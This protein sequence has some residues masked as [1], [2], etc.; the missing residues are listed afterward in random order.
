MTT[1]ITA[2]HGDSAVTEPQ[3][4]K[5]RRVFMWTFLAVQALFAI[6]LVTGIVSA[7]HGVPADAHAQAVTYCAGTGWQPLFK[8]H[9]DCMQHYAHGMAEA[10]QVGSAIGA[11]IVIFLWV[12]TDIVL[13]IGRIVVLTARR[14]AAKSE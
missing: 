7:A 8:S 6:W 4:R 2:P 1:N 10:G 12:A 13:G 11:G 14:R 9:A 5:R 3:P